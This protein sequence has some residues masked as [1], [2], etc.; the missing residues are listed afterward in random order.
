MHHSGSLLLLMLSIILGKRGFFLVLSSLFRFL[1]YDSF[2]S[3][4]LVQ[5]KMPL[6]L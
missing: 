4:A 2:F 5:F 1:F 3:L 6:N